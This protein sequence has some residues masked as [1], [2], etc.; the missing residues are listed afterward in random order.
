MILTDEERTALQEMMEALD[1]NH[2][3]QCALL[4]GALRKVLAA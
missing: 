4:V 3:P 1:A 2:C